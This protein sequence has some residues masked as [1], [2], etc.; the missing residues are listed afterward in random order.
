MYRE[1]MQYG[2]KWK[3]IPR[4]VNLDLISAWMLQHLVEF[5]PVPLGLLRGFHELR[6]ASGCDTEKGRNQNN[7]AAN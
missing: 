2:V 6:L 3:S 7:A 1:M 4:T 5:E